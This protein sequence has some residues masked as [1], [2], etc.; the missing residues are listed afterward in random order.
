MLTEVIEQCVISCQAIQSVGDLFDNRKR[1]LMAAAYHVG[2]VAFPP[3]RFA[4]IRIGDIEA[5]I[6]ECARDVRENGSHHGQHVG[7]RILCFGD[8][9]DIRDNVEHGIE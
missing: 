5:G 8:L 1:F 6:V 9:I 4:L 2:V 3:E 7:V